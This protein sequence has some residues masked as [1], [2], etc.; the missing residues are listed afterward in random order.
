MLNG[1]FVS[2]FAFIGI[3][4]AGPSYAA[5]T[6]PDIPACAVQSGAFKDAADFDECRKQMIAYKSGMET[7]ASCLKEAG[8]TQEQ[9]VQAELDS[10]LSRFNRRARGENAN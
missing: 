8:Q 6:K 5:C 3:L 10:G 7:Y 2:P 9:D 1:R 4:V